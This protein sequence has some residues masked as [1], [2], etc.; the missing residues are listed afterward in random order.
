MALAAMLALW[1]GSA[2]RWHKAQFTLRHGTLPLNLARLWRFFALRIGALW[3]RL[4]WRGG[5]GGIG[6]LVHR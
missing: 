6:G 1:P 4:S 5:C 2:L 3:V